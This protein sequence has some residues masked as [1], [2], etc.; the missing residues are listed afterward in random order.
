MKIDF[1]INVQDVKLA[2]SVTKLRELGLNSLMRT[3]YKHCVY[4]MGRQFNDCH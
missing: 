3:G 2:I 4:Q 1:S